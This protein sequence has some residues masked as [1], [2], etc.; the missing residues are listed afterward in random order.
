MPVTVALKP[1]AVA[2]SKAA[3]MS[4]KAVSAESFTKIVM[5]VP[6]M[7]TSGSLASTSLV[8]TNDT[9]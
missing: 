5:S 7:L 8:S 6:V 2:S 9:L 1:G 4:L 3:S